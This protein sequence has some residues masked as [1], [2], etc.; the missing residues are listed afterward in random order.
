[1]KTEKPIPSP[2]AAFMND[3]REIVVTREMI[4]GA[5]PNGHARA[6]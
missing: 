5:H 1:M 4:L 3:N 6:V 2:K